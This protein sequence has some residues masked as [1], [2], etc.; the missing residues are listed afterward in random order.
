M[1]NDQQRTSELDQRSVEVIVQSGSSGHDRDES[2]TYQADTVDPR[3]NLAGDDLATG[4]VRDDAPKSARR[5]AKLR[6]RFTI[7]KLIDYW[8]YLIAVLEVFLAARFFFELTGANQAAGF[9]RFVYG[10]SEPF[11]W[12][13]NAIFAVPRHA[14][15]VFD[16]NVIIAM[17]VYVLIGAGVARLLSMLIEPP[18]T[19]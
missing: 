19:G 13:F 17:I 5:E 15:Y 16:P 10:I 7:G 2:G 11:V 1:T 18:S 4:D 9:V 6:R 8:W 3:N 12:P 14:Q